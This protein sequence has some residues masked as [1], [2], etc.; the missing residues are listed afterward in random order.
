MVLG[1]GG[2]ECVKNH[3]IYNSLPCFEICNL[4]F[5]LLYLDG[6]YNTLVV[7]SAYNT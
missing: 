7:F 2:V 3:V 4:F 1:G 5:K 6:V